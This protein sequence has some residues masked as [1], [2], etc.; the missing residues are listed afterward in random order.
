[1]RRS[2]LARFVVPEASAPIYIGT[3]TIREEA[4]RYTMRVEDHYD[5]ALQR[6]KGRFPEISGPV[7][8]RL[9]ELR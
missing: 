5:Q 6:L 4:G 7:T 3:L 8:K 2:I 1:M 9:M